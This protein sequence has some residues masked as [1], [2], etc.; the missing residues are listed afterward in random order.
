LS[1]S[2]EGRVADVGGTVRVDAAPGAGTCVE[3][4]VPLPEP[5]RDPADLR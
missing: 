1:R 2:V 4:R 5:A 3:L